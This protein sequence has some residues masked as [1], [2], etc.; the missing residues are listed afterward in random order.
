MPVEGFRKYVL[1][2]TR[3][4]KRLSYT[5]HSGQTRKNRLSQR[6]ASRHGHGDNVQDQTLVN[7]KINKTLVNKK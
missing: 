2:L 5:S 1:S 6:P 7:T 4:F 3:P